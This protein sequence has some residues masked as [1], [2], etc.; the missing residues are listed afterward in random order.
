MIKGKFNYQLSYHYSQKVLH[1]NISPDEC[2]NYLLRLFSHYKQVFLQTEQG[3]F[4]LL[5]IKR[6]THYFREK[7]SKN[8]SL[9]EHN[10][11]KIT[12]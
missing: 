3:D 5:L 12:F 10:R 7:S 8:P 9:L 2:E 4:H 11:P 6:R 1:E